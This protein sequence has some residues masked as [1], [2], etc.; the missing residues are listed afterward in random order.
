MLR[1]NW[2]VTS[3]TPEKNNPLTAFVLCVVEIK[4]Y[5]E[6]SRFSVLLRKENMVAFSERSYGKYFWSRT[7]QPG[8]ITLEE[9]KTKLREP[10]WRHSCV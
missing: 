1:G 3:D 6:Y 7:A 2:V 9:F 10:G 4:E 8:T 5:E